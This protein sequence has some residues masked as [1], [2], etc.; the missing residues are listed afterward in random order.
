MD[1]DDYLNY[2]KRIKEKAIEAKKKL[3]SERSCDDRYAIWADK[4]Q[5]MLSTDFDSQWDEGEEIIIKDGEG[6]ANRRI[7]HLSENAE[8]PDWFVEMGKHF[9]KKVLDP[10]TSEVGIL[11]GMSYTYF[12]YYYVVE[13]PDGKVKGIS[14][15]TKI[16]ILED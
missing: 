14:C 15:V 4:R 5:N 6:L 8:F 2:L 9:G 1:K 16:E 11:I 12:D 10:I 3:P 13:C 7:R